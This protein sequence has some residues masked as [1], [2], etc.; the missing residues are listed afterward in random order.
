MRTL[1]L[2]LR[3]AALQE[4]ILADLLQ[5]LVDSLIARA[6]LPIELTVRLTDPLPPTIKIA[7]YR[8]AQEA[9]NNVVKHAGAAKVTVQLTDQPALTEAGTGPAALRT[10]ELIIRDDGGGFNP[11]TITPDHLGLNIMRERAAAVGIRLNI[12]SRIGRG[13]EVKASWSIG[14][15]S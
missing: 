9:L 1:L 7:F 4:V 6:R 5:Q 15:E 8:I 13:T 10:V 11:T 14:K 2:E 3:P 12:T